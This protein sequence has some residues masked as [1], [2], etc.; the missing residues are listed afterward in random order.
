MCSALLRGRVSKVSTVK[1]IGQFGSRFGSSLRLR[2]SKVSTLMSVPGYSS[3]SISDEAL[4]PS[5]PCGG[6]GKVGGG[7]GRNSSM[8][9]VLQTNPK[10]PAARV[11]DGSCKLHF[12]ARRHQVVVFFFLAP[13]KMVVECP[14]CRGALAEASL[15]RRHRLRVRESAA[16]LAM[17]V[18]K[19]FTGLRTSECLGKKFS[20]FRSQVPQR[21]AWGRNPATP[22][23]KA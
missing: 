12:R 3:P 1:G 9:A 20:E 11:V 7:M 13:Q 17:C 4:Q 6:R 21:A 10:K 23:P 22:K 16:F 5:Q 18:M 2:M 8:S 14:T 15:L 19:G